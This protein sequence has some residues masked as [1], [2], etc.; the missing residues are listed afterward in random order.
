[1]ISAKGGSFSYL[2]RVVGATPQL[3][4][5][6]RRSDDMTFEEALGAPRWRPSQSLAWWVPAGP[7]SG[8]AGK[9][10]RAD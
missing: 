8:R 6:V 4:L 2:G 3:I 10:T 1:M 5:N 7:L 9:S